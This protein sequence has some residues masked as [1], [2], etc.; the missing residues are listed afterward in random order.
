VPFA[1]TEPDGP[2][3]GFGVPENVP[4]APLPAVVPPAG[5]VAGRIV[6]ESVGETVAV[7]VGVLP[8]GDTAG[9]EDVGSDEGVGAAS[10]VGAVPDGLV[11]GDGDTVVVADD[12]G[13][14]EG[15][16]GQC[17]D[18]R[19]EDETGTGNAPAPLSALWVGEATVMAAVPVTAEPVPPDADSPHLS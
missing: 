19:V 2:G 18:E 9:D 8:V 1:S 16:A 12:V 10:E 4:E 14:P 15:G 17:A 6:P 13:L 3:P 5:E 11:C 7:A